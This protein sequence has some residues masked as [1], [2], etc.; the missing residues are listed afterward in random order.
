MGGHPYWYVVDYQEDIAAALNALRQREFLAGR[1]NPVIS[2][3]HKLFPIG[4]QSPAPGAAHISIREAVEAS[5]AD[6]T[7]SILDIER[8]SE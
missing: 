1:Y 5:D 2:Y 3:P 6:G 8:I 7:R 4:P